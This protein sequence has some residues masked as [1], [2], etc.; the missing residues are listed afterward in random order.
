MKTEGIELEFQEE[1]IKE[2][3]HLAAEI[4]SSIENIGARFV[5]SSFIPSFFHSFTFV[6]LK[7][8]QSLKRRLHTVIEKI[9]EDISFNCD[10]HVNEPVV[11]TPEKVK[12]HLSPMLKKMDLSR[13]IL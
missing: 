5:S 13:Y 7:F 1:S 8:T 2:I 6:S 4:N 3:A 11:I 10:K 12:E 9:M